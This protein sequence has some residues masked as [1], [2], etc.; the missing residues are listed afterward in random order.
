[1]AIKFIKDFKLSFFAKI[2]FIMALVIIFI[3]ITTM[4]STQYYIR[5]LDKKIEDKYKESL[6]ELRDSIDKI[7]FGVYSKAVDYAWS[8]DLNPIRNSKNYASDFKN[9]YKSFIQSDYYIHDVFYLDF[10][11]KIAVTKDGIENLNYFFK[12]HYENIFYK[13]IPI[14]SFDTYFYLISPVEFK[15][16]ELSYATVIPY[17]IPDK[18]NVNKMILINIDLQK[19]TYFMKQHLL[20]S[21]SNILILDE[22]GNIITNTDYSSFPNRSLKYNVNFPYNLPENYVFNPA[23][24]NFLKKINN[25]FFITVRKFAINK[26]LF[27]NYFF[28]KIAVV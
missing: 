25:N 17:L 24:N 2:F 28:D 10:L 16:N 4:L 22:S 7:L 23:G 3:I 6:D 21:D 1:L 9:G 12:Y 20:S 27:P 13:D 14:L 8:D 5:Y 26:P 11:K 19:I 15:V 18:G